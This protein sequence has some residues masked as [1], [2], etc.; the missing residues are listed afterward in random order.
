MSVLMIVHIFFVFKQKTTYEMRISD[1]SSD[2]CSS[3]LIDCEARQRP[4]SRGVALLQRAVLYGHCSG[5]GVG[6]AQQPGAGTVHDETAG[7]GHHT[8]ESVGAAKTA[9]EGEHVRIGI[10]RIEGEIAAQG[11]RA[12]AVVADADRAVRGPCAIAARANTG[13]AQ[14]A[15]I[16]EVDSRSG[17][18]GAGKPRI[19]QNPGADGDA[20]D[21]GQP[22][23]GIRAAQRDRT[24]GVAAEQV[25]AAAED[26]QKLEVCRLCP[27]GNRAGATRCH[28][29]GDR[30]GAGA[31]V[32]YS[33][34]IADRKSTRLNSSH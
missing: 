29:A 19:C 2:V 32:S 25:I 23:I 34:R 7:A 3:D 26:S 15:A 4:K 13:V 33:G 17:S 28:I 9:T 6:G 18:K 12:C 5:A 24:S 27:K 22:R 14:R 1:G 10:K 21:C 8:R 16:G 31:L 11:K 20:A 30:Q